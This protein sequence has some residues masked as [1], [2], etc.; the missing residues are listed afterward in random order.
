[1][2]VKGPMDG[3]GPPTL[4]ESY[5]PARSAQSCAAAQCR[6]DYQPISG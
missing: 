2:L 4:R 6:S 3:S 1:M 5:D